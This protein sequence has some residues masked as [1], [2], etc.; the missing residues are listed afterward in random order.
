MATIK[1][2]LAKKGSNTVSVSPHV[3]VR[4]AAGEMIDANVGCLLIAEGGRLVGIFTERDL[5]WRVVGSGKDPDETLIGQVMTSPVRTCSPDDD[6]AQCFDMLQTS[7]FRHLV[8]AEGG[9]P[10]GLISIRDVAL[11]LHGPI[12]GI[13][14]EDVTSAA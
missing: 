1:T 8:V 2:I 14:H 10:A 6:I 12:S 3:S 11:A 4:D 9:K 13:T 7:S 5:L